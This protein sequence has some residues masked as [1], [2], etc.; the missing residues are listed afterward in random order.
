MKWLLNY[1]NLLDFNLNNHNK[2]QKYYLFY[3]YS[4]NKCIDNNIICICS[5][6]LRFDFRLG[7][8]TIFEF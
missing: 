3:F 5:N 1:G 2:I 7:C 4:K 8:L 6:K